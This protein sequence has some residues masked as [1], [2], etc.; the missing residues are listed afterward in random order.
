MWKIAAALALLVAAVAAAP[1]GDKYTTK[2]DNVDVDEILHNE[3]LFSKYA[4]C[5]LDEGNERCTAD[6]KE[7]KVLIPDALQNECAKC[8]EKQKEGVEKVIKFLVKEKKDI[9]ERLR[10][11][12]DPDGSYYKNYEH[13]LKE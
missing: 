4:D 10:A 7:L 11:K 8:N 9:W 5:L 6:G 3:R 13:Y 1:D 12:Y 2:Y